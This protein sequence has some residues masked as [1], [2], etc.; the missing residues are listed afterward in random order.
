MGWFIL[1][2]TVVLFV[3]WIAGY[4]VAYDK[5]APKHCKY[6]GQDGHTFTHCPMVGKIQ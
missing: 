2:I 4:W 6:C 3:G 5:Y 1:E